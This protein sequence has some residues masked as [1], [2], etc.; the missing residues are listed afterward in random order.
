MGVSGRFLAWDRSEGASL[1][2]DETLSPHLVESIKPLITIVQSLKT[3]ELFI[4]Q[5]SHST[6]RVLGAFIAATQR[7]ITDFRDVVAQLE[8]SF[9]SGSIRLQIAKVHVVPFE[10]H[11]GLLASFVTELEQSHASGGALL[12]RLEYLADRF[13]GDRSCRS[14]VENITAQSAL[15]FVHMLR[16]WLEAGEVDDPCNEFMVGLKRPND[17]ANCECPFSVYE[18]LHIRH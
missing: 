9:A 5:K 10:K 14:F 4:V 8:K 15:P 16:S 11:L 13:S 12:R 7:Y 2:V 18:D 6:G 17:T 3:I 1:L